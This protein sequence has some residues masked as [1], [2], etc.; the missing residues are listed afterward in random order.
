MLTI[1]DCNGG[2]SL[3]THCL[4]VDRTSYINGNA[5]VDYNET[6]LPVIQAGGRQSTDT[7]NALKVP[8]GP[9]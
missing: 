4:Q 1:A 2:G 5:C 8:L 9:N 3:E 6:S 7:M